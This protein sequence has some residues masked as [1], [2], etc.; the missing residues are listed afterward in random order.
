AL[1]SEGGVKM[2]RKREEIDFEVRDIFP[3]KGKGL[4]LEELTESMLPLIE[5]T[6]EDFRI[7]WKLI[8]PKLRRKLLKAKDEGW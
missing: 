5:E 4:S 7:Y 3:E 2:A 1:H 8:K 6:L